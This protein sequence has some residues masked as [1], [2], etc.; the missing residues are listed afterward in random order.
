MIQ[1][2]KPLPLSFPAWITYATRNTCKKKLMHLLFPLFVDGPEQ[3][4]VHD[5]VKESINDGLEVEEVGVATESV[6]PG[7]PH[8]ERVLHRVEKAEND[9]NVALHVAQG[10]SVVKGEGQKLQRGV[11]QRGIVQQDCVQLKF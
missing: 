2:P 8:E 7:D 4:N 9:H 11:H 10:E 3:L 5:D 6:D 1:M